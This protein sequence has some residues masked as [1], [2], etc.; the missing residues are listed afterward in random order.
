MSNKVYIVV[1]ENKFNG[2][3]TRIVYVYP[4]HKQAN[5]FIVKAQKADD[6]NFYSIDV[7][8]IENEA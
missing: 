1:K 7:R 4:T 2:G 3:G 5:S 8:E 6:K